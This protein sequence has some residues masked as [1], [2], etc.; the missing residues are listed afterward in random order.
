MVSLRLVTCALFIRTI[1]GQTYCSTGSRISSSVDGSYE[2]EYTNKLG[3][4]YFNEDKEQYL[5]PYESGSFKQY[6][7][8]DDP[9][10][11]IP[12]TFIADSISTLQIDS[13]DY[14]FNIEDFSQ[15][16]RSF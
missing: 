16:W 2:Y 11:S 6:I 13:I 12:N 9:S 1:Y 8:G 15:N 10:V 4:V 5:F 7:I 14:E 3:A